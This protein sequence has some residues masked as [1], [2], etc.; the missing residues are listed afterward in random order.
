[1]INTDRI[2]AAILNLIMAGGL[3]LTHNNNRIL[4][5]MSLL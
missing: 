1:M 4:N 3:D 5:E 2:L